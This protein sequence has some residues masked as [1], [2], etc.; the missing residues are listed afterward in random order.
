MPDITTLSLE[1]LDEELA[2]LDSEIAALR[3]RLQPL[4]ARRAK[5][6]SF[7]SMFEEFI[8]DR[9]VAE[10]VDEP[11]AAASGLGLT[12]VGGAEA[13][14]GESRQWT[15]TRNLIRALESRGFKSQAEN[16]YT[17]V[18]GTLNREV[19]RPDTKLAKRD[20]KWGLLEWLST[21]AVEEVVP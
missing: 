16:V 1:D 21:K 11:E 20:G 17:S 7:K 12:I 5:V 19:K 2:D 10:P 8:A 4:E 13:V 15:D 9:A 6:V 3:D 18:F 14:L